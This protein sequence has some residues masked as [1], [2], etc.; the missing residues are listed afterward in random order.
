MSPSHISDN[1]VF[2][3]DISPD[4]QAQVRKF[5]DAVVTRGAFAHSVGGKLVAREVQVSNRE[6]D[7]KPQARVVYEMTVDEGAFHVI[8]SRRVAG[9]TH[10]VG[11]HA[12][13]GEDSPWR[14]RGLSH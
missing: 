8:I 14:L 13:L 10:A 2:K 7:G 5:A 3:G 6:K 12:E 9:L 4:V 1:I 11:R